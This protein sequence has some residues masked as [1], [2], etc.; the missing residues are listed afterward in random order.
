VAKRPQITRAW[1]RLGS[2]TTTY[3]R[4]LFLS[5]LGRTTPRFP[6]VV[7]EPSNACHRYPENPASMRDSAPEMARPGLEPGTPRFS[8]VRVG[9]ARGPQIPGSYV[10]SAGVRRSQDVRSL[11]T[12]IA[13][14]GNGRRLRPRFGT[15]AVSAASASEHARGFAP[16]RLR[17]RSAFGTDHVGRQA[18]ISVKAGTNAASPPTTVSPEQA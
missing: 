2:Q 11:R 4:E 9:A 17:R 15:R 6:G 10:V 5:R 14:C 13:V 16:C 18:R 3:L 12:F 8:V 7:S 1:L